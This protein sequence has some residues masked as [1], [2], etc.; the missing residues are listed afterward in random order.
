MRVELMIDRQSVA[1]GD[2]PPSLLFYDSWFGIFIVK[3][4][5]LTPQML[6]LKEVDENG[7]N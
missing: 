6:G 1:R 7:N 4:G 5:P 3:Y 2:W